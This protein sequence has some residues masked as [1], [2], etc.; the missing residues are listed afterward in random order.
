LT[1]GLDLGDQWAH[2]C[3]LDASNRQ[4][5]EGRV[6]LTVKGLKKQ[7]P[8][9]R[10]ARIALEAGAQS[11]W[12]CRTLKALGHEVIVAQPRKLRLIYCNDKKCDRVDAA[13][14]AKFARLDPTVLHPIEPRDLKTQVDLA[15]VEARALSV[16]TRTKLI[17]HVRGICKS[18]GVRLPSCSSESFARKVADDIP[19]SLQEALKPMLDLLGHLSETIAHYDERLEEK[20]QGKYR[21]QT[22]AMRQI[23]GVGPVTALTFALRIGEP[24]RFKKSRLVGAFLGLRPRL[25]QSGKTDRQLGITKAGDKALRRLLVQAAHY[26]LGPF[27]PESDLRNWGLQMAARGGAAAKKRAVVAVA[28]KMAVLMHRLW[29]TGEVYEPLRQTHR[30]AARAVA[31]TLP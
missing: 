31:L 6:A 24:T 7:F 1:I 2:Y 9:G 17:N 20:C 11:A 19:A 3:G 13:Q 22:E 27:G 29:I 12:V 14:L 18:N 16:A 10:P 8:K 15:I 25:D 26:T 23:P 4:V 30:R 28:R 21:K 5:Q